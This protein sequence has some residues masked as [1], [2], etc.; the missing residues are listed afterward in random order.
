MEEGT[1]GTIS[2]EETS[3]TTRETHGFPHSAATTPNDNIQSRRHSAEPSSAT[4]TD[5][6]EPYHP[7]YEHFRRKRQP[8]HPQKRQTPTYTS[9]QDRPTHPFTEIPTP[10]RHRGRQT[11]T[12]GTADRMGQDSWLNCNRHRVHPIPTQARH[13]SRQLWR[14]FHLWFNGPHGTTRWQYLWR[15]PST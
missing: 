11:G 4:T 13:L 6:C 5:I 8:V 3:T 9:R 2:S 10:P 15:Q 14:M 12:P 1:G 7:F